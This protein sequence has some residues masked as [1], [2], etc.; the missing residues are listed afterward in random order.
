MSSTNE[1]KITELPAVW[2]IGGLAMFF[3]LARAAKGL[4]FYLRV[5]NAYFLLVTAATY[6]VLA[7]VTLR[8]IGKKS[9]AQWATARAFAALGCPGLGIKFEVEGEEYMSTRPAVFISNHQSELDI[10]ML[11]RVSE[12]SGSWRSG[13]SRANMGGWWCRCSRSIPASQLS[14]A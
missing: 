9:I 13:K 10:L 8:L 2:I 1:I 6:G 14:G 3:L 7:S 11:G 12:L 5:V 4:R